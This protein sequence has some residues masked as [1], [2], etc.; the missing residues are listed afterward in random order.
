MLVIRLARYGAKKKPVYRVVVIDKEQP[1]DGA[2]H[3]IVGQYNPRTSPATIIL[4]RERIE[5]WMSKGAQP[6]ATVARL[7]K[8][9]P[10][11]PAPAEVA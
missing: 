11:A 10:A 8:V 7:M 1:R 9:A 2:A 5:H 4:N 6:S 3:E